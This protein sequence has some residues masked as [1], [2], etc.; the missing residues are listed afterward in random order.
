MLA[1][2]VAAGLAGELP[3]LTSSLKINAK[4]SFEIG[5]NMACGRVEQG[6]VDKAEADL[7]QALK[8]GACDSCQSGLLLS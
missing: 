1:A 4:S 2:Y 3:Q 7:R 5:F 6:L 8:Q